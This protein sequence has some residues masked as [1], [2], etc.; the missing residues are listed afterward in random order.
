MLQWVHR[1]IAAFG[2]DPAHVFLFGTS[3]GGGN[4]CAL[5]TS[6]LTKGLIHGVAM[7][8]SVPA[9]CEIQTLAD[10]EKGTGERVTKALGCDGAAAA[11]P[12][13]PRIRA[14]RRTTPRAVVRCILIWAG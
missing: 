12:A 13:R 8:S 11:V 3:A 2:G 14:K 6:P 1:N 7:E 4:I 10:A 9:G 5:L